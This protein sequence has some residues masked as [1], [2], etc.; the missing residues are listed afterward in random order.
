MKILI[1]TNIGFITNSSSVVHH[2]P[3]KLLEHPKIAQFMSIFGLENGFVGENMW[4]RGECATIAVT[5]EQKEKVARGMRELDLEEPYSCS[6][7]AI[8]VDSDDI[9]VVYGDEYQSVAN[10]LAHML[11]DAANELGLQYSGQDFN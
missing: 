6:G 5:K 3:R 11:K 7:P 1:S 4:H 8:D 2:F 9:V 10:E